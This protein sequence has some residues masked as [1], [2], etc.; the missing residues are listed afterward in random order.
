MTAAAICVRAPTARDP[1]EALAAQAA[2]APAELVVLLA[3]HARAERC[4]PGG[5]RSAPRRCARARPGR[6]RRPA[7]GARLASA[8]SD[9][10]AAAWTLVASITVSRPGVEPLAG[11]EVQHLERVGRGGLVVLV[12]ADQRAAE[13]RRQHL[14][15]PEVP[16]RANVDLPGAGDADQDDERQLRDLD[17]A[18]RR[19]TASCVGRARRGI[20]RPDPGQLDPVAMP[21]GHFPGPLARTAA[22][23]HS[24]RW[25]PCRSRARRKVR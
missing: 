25:S 11:D 9:C 24:K 20:G 21:R 3:Q 5:P 13:V 14:G 1:V 6:S 7:R 15:G 8:I 17:R 16:A 23:V 22:R 2:Q 12:V 18:H 19:N 4:G 10:R